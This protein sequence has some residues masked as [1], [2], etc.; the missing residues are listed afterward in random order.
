MRLVGDG[1][2]LLEAGLIDSLDEVDL[3][4]GIAIREL[5]V[6]GVVE[7]FGKSVADV[8]EVADWA[9]LSRPTIETND[10]AV[11]PGLGPGLEESDVIGDS[12]ERVG[13]GARGVV[14]WAIDIR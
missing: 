9:D 13:Q 7:R 6:V 12:A 11:V 5:I 10:E 1:V 3:L 14:P 2:S 4:V 8:V